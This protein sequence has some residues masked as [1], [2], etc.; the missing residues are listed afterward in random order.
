[1]PTAQYSLPDALLVLA[2]DRESGHDRAASTPLL[3]VGAALAE[4]ALEG[5]LEA[6]DSR[7]RRLRPTAKRPSSHPFLV[8][9]FDSLSE[10]GWDRPARDL[11]TWLGGK[12][13]VLD[14]L[15]DHLIGQGVL[16]RSRTK[17]LGL[18]PVTTYPQQ[19]HQPHDGLVE[20]LSAVLFE[21]Q[22]PEIRDR[23]LM[24]L[25]EHGGTLRRHLDRTQLREHRRRVRELTSRKSLMVGAPG[26]AVD[27]TVAATDAAVDA[28]VIAVIAAGDASSDGGDGGGGE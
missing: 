13:G 5:V 6:D 10:R 11:V 20:R 21:G 26:R 23:V 22:E 15:R 19:S 24:V 25:A 4:L 9:V 3:A 8:H 2:L 27:G 7:K 16:S 12:R 1:M 14:P 18:I 17:I 28:A